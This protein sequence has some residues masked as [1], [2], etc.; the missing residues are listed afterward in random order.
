MNFLSLCLS[1]QHQQQQQQQQH[2]QEQ[3]QHCYQDEDASWELKKWILTQIRDE[4]KTTVKFYETE[5]S[6]VK[7]LSIHHIIFFGGLI[8]KN[9]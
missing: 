4:D 9:T 1:Q 2:Q 7:A 6:F 8:W 5:M 3:Q